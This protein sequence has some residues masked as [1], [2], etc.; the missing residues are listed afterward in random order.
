VL[1]APLPLTDQLYAYCLGSTVVVVVVVV[2]VPLTRQVISPPWS[3]YPGGI[4]TS[5]S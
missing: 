5:T 4:V 1:S 3:K 2:P